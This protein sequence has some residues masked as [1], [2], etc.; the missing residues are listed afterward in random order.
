MWGVALALRLSLSPRTFLHEGYHIA[1]TVSGYLTGEMPPI[2]GKTGPALFRLAGAVMQRPDDVQVIFVTNAVLASLAVPALA[3][4][5]LAL[6]HSWPR[7]VCA[8]ALVCVLPLHLRFSAAEDLFVQATTFG[9]WAVALFALYL[10]TRRIEDAVW[11]ALALSLAM[12][13][14]PEMLAFPAVLVAL[15]LLV[16]PRSWRVLVTWRT[17]AALSMLGLLLIPRFFEL[18]RAL[19]G[20]PSPGL[21]FPPVSH[22]VEN[23]VL[24]QPQVTPPVYCAFLAVG[25]AWGVWRQPRVHLWLIAVFVGHTVVTLSIFT[26]VPY[27]LR[28]QLLPTSCAVLIAAGVASVWVEAWTRVRARDRKSL[29]TFTTTSTTPLVLGACALAGIGAIVVRGSRDFVTSLGDQQLEWAFI[30]PTVPQ[31]P[32]RGTLLSAIEAGGS[33][34]DAFPAFVLSGAGKTYD[35][36]D[37]RRATNGEVAWPAPGG[38]LLYYQGLFCYLAPPGQPSSERLTA[39]CGAVHERYTLDAS[40]TG[41]IAGE[42]WQHYAGN[43]RGPFRIGFFRLQARR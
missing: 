27:G 10:R 2:Y 38:E 5:D 17:L 8:A 35:L 20:G 29:F 3:L 26:N 39:P 7:A 12:Q 22:Y 21:T 19:H 42:A 30:E 33:N 23:L 18:Q 40:M 16:E 28:S 11:V 37:V 1:E 6:L 32:A 15:V 34:L 25:L 4:L 14:R 13:A 24:I 36:V 43:S 31:L 9:V 41:D